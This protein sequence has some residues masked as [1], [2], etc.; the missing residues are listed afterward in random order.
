MS[1]LTSLAQILV[2]GSATES[3]LVGKLVCGFD[4]LLAGEA[5]VAELE[6]SSS[7]VLQTKY[8][9]A[10]VG[11]VYNRQGDE[12]LGAIITALPSLGASVEEFVSS[13]ADQNSEA[14]DCVPIR[15]LAV[16]RQAGQDSLKEGEK[17]K[18]A[19]WALDHGYELVDIDLETVTATHDEREKEGLPRLIEALHANMWSGM[20]RKEPKV[21]TEVQREPAS[22]PVL[23]TSAATVNDEDDNGGVEDEDM[24][25]KFSELLASARG[26]R[27]AASQLSDDERRKGA[28]EFALQLAAMLGGEEDEDD[29]DEVEQGGGRK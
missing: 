1:A 25:E 8:Y 10:T 17:Y 20:E 29:D 7:V 4:R 26:F 3:L 14:D 23:T 11:L 6:E 12:Q 13:S 24:L 18:C 28:S 2:R 27:E 9:K 22:V 5:S 19:L 21:A 16:V 15:L